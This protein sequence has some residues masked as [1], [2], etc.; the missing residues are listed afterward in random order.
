MLAQG[1]KFSMNKALN[2]D[3]LEG[4]WLIIR[5]YPVEGD[6]DGDPIPCKCTLY[7]HSSQRLTV[8]KV[9]SVSM[10]IV[11][12]VPSVS[13]NL[14]CVVFEGHFTK[15]GG[16]NGTNPFLKCGLIQIKQ[17]EQNKSPKE[18]VKMSQ[19]I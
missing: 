10:L 18:I 19:E 11:L 16:K 7:P 17:K 3:K 13:E 14:S 1:N 15:Q 5:T 8:R 2:P 6:D 9:K 12:F 4:N